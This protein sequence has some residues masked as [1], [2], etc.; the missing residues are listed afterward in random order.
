MGDNKIKPIIKIKPSAIKTELSGLYEAL[1]FTKQQQMK[2]GW[3]FLGD[4]AYQRK[5]T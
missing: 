1:G 3:R 4:G 5:I 2:D